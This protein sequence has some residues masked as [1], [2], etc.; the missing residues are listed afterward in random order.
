MEMGYR[1]HIVAK[2]SAL[3]VAGGTTAMLFAATPVHTQ[4]SAT[5]NGSLSASGAKVAMVLGNGNL[6]ATNLQPGQWTDTRVVDLTNTG[7]VYVDY[8]LYINPDSLTGYLPN[9]SALQQLKYSY[10]AYEC[11]SYTRNPANSNSCKTDGTSTGTVFPGITGGITTP[12]VDKLT[13]GGVAPKT[14]LEAVISFGLHGYGATYGATGWTLSANT[15][16]PGGANAWNGAS[17]SIP[18]SIIA[19]PVGGTGTPQVAPTLTRNGKKGHQTLHGVTNLLSSRSVLERRTAEGKSPVCERQQ[20]PSRHPSSAGS[21][22]VG[23]N[24]RR[25]LRKAKY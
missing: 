25:P 21:V 7:N 23:V 1:D 10:T 22:K 12:I 4:F 5:T 20:A 17:V 13:S 19:E 9:K 14:K 11:T 16:I 15:S 6:V 18:Y 3:A 2:L 8:Y 24:L